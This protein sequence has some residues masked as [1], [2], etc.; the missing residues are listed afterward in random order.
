MGAGE[1][2]AAE[3]NDWSG[4]RIG[5]GEGAVEEGEITMEELDEALKGT[6]NKKAAGPDGIP[7]EAWKLLD[8]EGAR[9][10]L[11]EFLNLC[12]EKEQFPGEWAESTVV[13]IFKN[14]GT[15]WTQRITGQ[16][17]CCKRHTRYLGRLWQIDCRRG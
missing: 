13:G 16:S 17:P 14:K 2:A 7:A 10:C 4:P 5:H 9:A 1:N 11:L 8:G 15:P 3:E 6:A 12:W